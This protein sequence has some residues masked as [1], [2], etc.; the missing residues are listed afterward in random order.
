MHRA[1]AEWPIGPKPPV[2]PERLFRDGP[3]IVTVGGPPMIWTAAPTIRLA[4]VGR[5]LAVAVP[6]RRSAPP[7]GMQVDA[8]RRQPRSKRR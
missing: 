1:S 2:D 3:L 8:G 6:E 4:A 7:V 5:A